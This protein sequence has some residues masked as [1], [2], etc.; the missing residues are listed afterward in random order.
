MDILAI[1]KKTGERVTIVN[2]RDKGLCDIIRNNEIVIENGNK[3]PTT[4]RL[5]LVN[6]TD[7]III[8]YRY[9]Q[10]D[11]VYIFKEG[12]NLNAYNRETGTTVS[13]GKDN[14]YKDKTVDELKA[15]M[16][17]QKPAPSYTV[18][19]KKEEK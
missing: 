1:Y 14:P 5:D 17:V 13:V 7:L 2:I 11:N 19:G 12:D 4:A 6:K 16:K 8:D 18:L 15:I 10:E 9:L 3:K